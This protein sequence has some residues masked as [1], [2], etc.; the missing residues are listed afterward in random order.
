MPTHDVSLRLDCVLPG[1]R[2]VE[3]SA[4]L[5]GFGGEKVLAFVGARAWFENWR[6]GHFLRIYAT[7]MCGE[8][9]RQNK[10][11][12]RVIWANDEHP[13]FLRDL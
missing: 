1:P 5:S 4:Y 6:N 12:V 10:S 9:E 13:D 3:V 2:R 11:L 8:P 7:Y